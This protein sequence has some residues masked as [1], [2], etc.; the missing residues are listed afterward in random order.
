M[1]HLN[2]IGL[3]DLARHLRG[4]FG[5][6]INVNGRNVT[7]IFDVALRDSYR[8]AAVRANTFARPSI[9][10]VNAALDLFF[11]AAASTALCH[12]CPNCDDGQNYYNKRKDNFFAKESVHE[13]VFEGRFLF[14]A[15][16]INA[17][18]AHL[19]L[20]RR[21]ILGEL[22]EPLIASHR[23]LC[24]FSGAALVLLLHVL[25]VLADHVFG[26]LEVVRDHDALWQREVL[27]KLNSIRQLNVVR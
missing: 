15:C 21:M 11:T 14:S 18:H 24:R 10:D 17:L 7:I 3:V 1:A 22:F 6:T 5:E 12:E 4:A 8:L 2:I 16:L 13:L 27:W 26:D 20:R 19:K 25:E 9:I 23:R